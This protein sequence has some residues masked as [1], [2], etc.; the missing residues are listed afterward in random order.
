MTGKTR[1]IVISV[2]VLSIVM[3]FLTLSCIDSDAR[4]GVNADGSGTVALTY[5]VSPLV[6][7]LGSLDE[8]DPV[9]PLP[10]SEEDFI[11][12]VAAIPGLELGDYTTRED[13]DGV[14]IT[15]ELSFQS[16]GALNEFIGTE[17]GEFSLTG[18][19]GSDRLRY[20]IYE[21]VEDGIAEESV[22]LARDFFSDSFLRFTVDTP[23]DIR[24]A[25]SGTISDNRRSITLELNT[26]DLIVDNRDVIWEVT[27]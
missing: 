16:A 21:A 25:N 1:R 26:A 11:R 4:I 19:E 14:T 6:M 2:V 23:A 7:N 20:V 12:T 24:S 9:L 22:T 18:I 8:D 17:A 5:T 13:E 27:W 10:V 15:A 3:G